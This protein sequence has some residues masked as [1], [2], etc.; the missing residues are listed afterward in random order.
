MSNPVLEHG[1]FAREGDVASSAS[2]AMTVGGS[3]VK[4]LILLVVLI[5]TAGITHQS[6]AD[7]G[8]VFGLQPQHVLIGGILGALVA[9]VIGM[10]AKRA[11]AIFGFIYALLK[12]AVVGVV[13]FMYGAMYE[14]LPM[15]AAVFTLPLF[16]VCW[17]CSCRVRS[18][19]RRASFA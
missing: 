10:M 4:T 7:T 15:L 5:V 9:V 2:S 11:A 13:V 18:G 12:G 17:C 1:G 3:I 19:L 14:G 16:S 6:I 8:T